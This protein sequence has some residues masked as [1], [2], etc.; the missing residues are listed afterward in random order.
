M[1]QLLIRNNRILNIMDFA[2][3]PKR[4]RI[5]IAFSNNSHIMTGFM[6]IFGKSIHP[7]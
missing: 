5:A 6:E 2:P 3:L 1:P 4:C 7:K